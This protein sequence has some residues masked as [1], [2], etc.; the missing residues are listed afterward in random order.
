M[1]LKRAFS[2]MSEEFEIAHHH[3][4][5]ERFRSPDHINTGFAEGKT[6]GHGF[7]GIE[8][9]G[10]KLIQPILKNLPITGRVGKAAIVIVGKT[11]ALVADL[12]EQ[13]M[14]DP[15]RRENDTQFRLRFFCR[16]V[17][18]IVKGLGPVQ[19]SG[20]KKSGIV[21]ALAMHE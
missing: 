6:R 16:V 18:R 12:A 10:N 7:A 8:R 5:T 21:R 17:S 4:T 15:V 3:G 2:E 20:V 19:R 1:N 13:I 14:D 11:S 9:G